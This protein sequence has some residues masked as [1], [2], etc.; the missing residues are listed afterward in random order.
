VAGLMKRLALGSY[1][2][3]SVGIGRPVNADRFSR[4]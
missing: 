3:I 2:I 1:V 4:I